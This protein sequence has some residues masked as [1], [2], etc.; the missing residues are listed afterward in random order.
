MLDHYQFQVP[1]IIP[2]FECKCRT[3]LLQNFYKA[4]RIDFP[5]RN[6]RNKMTILLFF[7]VK[8][9]DSSPLFPYNF[10]TLVTILKIILGKDPR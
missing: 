4:F 5:E 10:L 6:G 2:F 9:M 7:I 1:A 8:D 3:H